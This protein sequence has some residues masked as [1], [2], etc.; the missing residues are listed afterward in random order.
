MT[1][2][3]LLIVLLIAN[4]FAT[5]WVYRGQELLVDRV[6]RLSCVDT[7]AAGAGLSGQQ[8]SPP[9]VR[10]TNLSDE[11]A[12]RMPGSADAV[13]SSAAGIDAGID[14]AVSA[15]DDRGSFAQGDAQA[16]AGI[17]EEPE[18]VVDDLDAIKN[19]FT[20]QA[21]D[22]VQTAHV[23][24]T[25]QDVVNASTTYLGI[26]QDLVGC[27]EK[28]CKLVLGYADQA[29]FEAFVDDLIM[30]FNDELSASLY[31]DET[32]TVGGNSTVDV[33]LVRE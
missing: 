27:K 29:V 23:Y 28:V 13:R 10:A 6:D 22:S 20:I 2:Q 14:E 8:S 16:V 3:R 11:R 24:R 15:L 9:E 25:I 33:Y 17:A 21:V 31:F 4:L 12:E 32:H 7:A 18:V 1:G 5:L 19:Q 26:T 30:A